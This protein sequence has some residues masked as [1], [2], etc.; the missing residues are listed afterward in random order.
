MFMRQAARY[1]KPYNVLCN[2]NSPIKPL[3]HDVLTL[4]VVR[5]HMQDRKK[6][7]AMAMGS[8]YEV[9]NCVR[10]S[11]QL[12]QA[13]WYG[14]PQGEI[15]YQDTYYRRQRDAYVTSTTA[16][17]VMIQPATMSLQRKKP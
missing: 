8:V 16:L 12:P 6:H 14:Q 5:P 2:F 17:T 1:R 13:H 9:I 7:T 4:N 11:P 15:D 10:N 3:Y